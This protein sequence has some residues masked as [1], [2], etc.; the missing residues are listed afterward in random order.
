MDSE[1]PVKPSDESVLNYTRRLYPV[2]LMRFLRFC[3]EYN[4]RVL[5]IIAGFCAL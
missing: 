5:W 4:K 1:R 2:Y 3:K